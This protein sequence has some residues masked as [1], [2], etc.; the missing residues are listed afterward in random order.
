M[1]SQNQTRTV[2]LL[3]SRKM[4]VLTFFRA[5][6]NEDESIRKRI[7]NLVFTRRQKWIGSAHFAPWQWNGN[8]SD[9][10]IHTHT[11]THTWIAAVFHRPP[12]GMIKVAVRD[13]RLL[14]NIADER[15]SVAWQRKWAV[16]P[17][18]KSI[19]WTIWQNSLYRK[20]QILLLFL[21]AWH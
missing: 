16:V 13:S 6:T 9:S 7:R 18:A 12:V 10:I 1:L 11:H 21:R 5:E 14:L 2:P 15:R 20:A 17:V 8:G 19:T 3:F 4:C